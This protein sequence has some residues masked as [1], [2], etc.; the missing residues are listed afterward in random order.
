MN[1]DRKFFEEY[2]KELVKK[3]REASGLFYDELNDLLKAGD[4]VM[5]DQSLINK[6]NRGKYTFAFALQV[7]HAMGVKSIKIP[8]PKQ[9][10]LDPDD[11]R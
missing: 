6:I 1:G 4:V 3:K 7:L 11:E 5:N 8:D 9:A 2:A 10:A